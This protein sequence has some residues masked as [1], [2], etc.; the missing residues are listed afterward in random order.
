MEEKL[1]TD[2][3]PRNMKNNEEKKNVPGGSHENKLE[4]TSAIINGTSLK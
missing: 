3:N 2:I 1:Q 4:T